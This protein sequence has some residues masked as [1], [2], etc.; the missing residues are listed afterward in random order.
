MGISNPD[1]PSANLLGLA[2]DNQRGL[3]SLVPPTGISNREPQAV[4]TTPGQSTSFLL[5]TE[6]TFSVLTKFWGLVLPSCS[7][8]VRVGKQS[9]Q[10]HQTPPLSCIFR[11][12]PFTHYFLVVPTCPVPLLGRDHLIKIGASISFFSSFWFFMAGFHL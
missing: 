12:I 7:F 8:I 5:G 2:L 9:Y 1:D 11:D 4:I 10:V 6:V 3:G